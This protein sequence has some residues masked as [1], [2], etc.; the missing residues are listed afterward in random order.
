M[1]VD[2]QDQRVGVL[3]S[4]GTIGCGNIG[5]HRHLEWQH[6]VSLLARILVTALCLLPQFIRLDYDMRTYVSFR[7]QEFMP[8]A[9][10][11]AILEAQY[12]VQSRI[13]F[14]VPEVLR[15]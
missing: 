5:A 9:D 4:E 2:H 6:I 13:V 3:H 12:P 7:Y 10:K 15:L 14:T 8:A 11:P 1:T